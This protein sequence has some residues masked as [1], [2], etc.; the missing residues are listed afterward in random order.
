M[1][2]F[3]EDFVQRLE[4]LHGMA[5]DAIQSLSVEALDWVPGPDM[6]SLAVLVV[7]TCQ[8]ERYWVSVMGGGESV[9]RTRSEEFEAKGLTAV[10]LQAQL[11]NTLS[12]SRNTLS[13]LTLADLATNHKSPMHNRDFAVS[14]SLLHALDHTAEHAGQM[15][16]TRQLWERQ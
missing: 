15:A 13:K 4:D 6:N 10:Q 16:M 14:W 5:S 1:E 9:P 2:P 8:A 3:F 12:Q 7:H 11:D